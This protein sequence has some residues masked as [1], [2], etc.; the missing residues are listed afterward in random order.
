MSRIETVYYI[1]V[2]FHQVSCHH[3]NT[4]C[5]Q[6]LQIFGSRSI[7]VVR[8]FL[9]CGLYCY[10]YVCTYSE[11]D[12]YRERSDTQIDVLFSVHTTI[13]AHV[14]FELL[15][16]RSIFFKKINSVL[17]IV[18]NIYPH[19]YLSPLKETTNQVRAVFP[20]IVFRGTFVFREA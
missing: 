14:L 18:S 15:F 5:R 13:T 19:C 1:N 16:V 9:I 8:R 2:F 11:R 10:V 7:S 20:K 4:S 3:G 17:V 12:S 6:L